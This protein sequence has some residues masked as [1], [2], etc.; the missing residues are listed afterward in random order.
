[1]TDLA[2]QGQLFAGESPLMRLRQIRD[3]LTR[4]EPL[5]LERN[6]LILQAIERGYSERKIAPAAGLSQGRVHQIKAEDH[7]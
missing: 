6:R 3:M 2:E 4:V 5:I 1:M 7:D